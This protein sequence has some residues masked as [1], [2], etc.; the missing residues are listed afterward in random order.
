MK[1]RT[2]SKSMFLSLSLLSLISCSTMEVDDYNA[3]NEASVAASPKA[4]P[5]R[6]ITSFTRALQCMD[7][8]F[9]RYNISNL[10]IGAQDVVD[11]TAKSRVPTKVML[12]TALSKMSQRSKRFGLWC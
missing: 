8:L 7:N 5:Q 10:L 9:V 6:T 3:T 11:P 1:M 4:K 2:L 12:I